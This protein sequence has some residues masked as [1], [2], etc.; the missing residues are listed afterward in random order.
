MNL[1]FGVPHPGS[2]ANFTGPNGAWDPIL[3]SGTNHWVAVTTTFGQLRSKPIAMAK[4][5]RLN[6]DINKIQSIE[7]QLH[8]RFAIDI[9]E[10]GS[11]H[12]SS[13]RIL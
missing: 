1:W 4:Y 7:N 5:Q 12:G 13:H 3:T 6:E 2:S 9:S 10:K 8:C 11:S